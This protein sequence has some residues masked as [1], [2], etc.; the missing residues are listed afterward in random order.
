MPLLNISELRETS[1]FWFYRVKP[2]SEMPECKYQLTRFNF[3]EEEKILL[4]TDDLD[5]IKNEIKKLSTEK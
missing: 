1:A 5:L 4:K 2:S 3:G